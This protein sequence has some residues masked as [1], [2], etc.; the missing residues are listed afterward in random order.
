MP[1]VAANI[2]GWYLGYRDAPLASPTPVT[3]NTQPAVNS[4]N[5]YKNLLNLFS[6]NSLD[7]VL[8]NYPPGA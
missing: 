3:I 7:T 4:Q 5:L 8:Y 6:D 2:G 1:V